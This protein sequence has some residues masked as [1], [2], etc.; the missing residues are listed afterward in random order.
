MIPRYARPEMEA[1]WTPETRFQI[2]L[3]IEA[4]AME[5]LAKGG[6]IPE[7]AARTYR[8]KGNF[9]VARIDEI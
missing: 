5:A 3:D 7:S 4:Y 9:N 2:W 1:I 6:V 8:E